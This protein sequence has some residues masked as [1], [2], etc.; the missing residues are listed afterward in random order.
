M[1]DKTLHT[2]SCLCGGVRYEIR[3]ELRPVHYCHCSQ[4]RKTSGN[5]VAATGCSD[6]AFTWVSDSTLSWYRASE[7]ARRGFCNVCGSNLFWKPDGEARIAI[8]AGTLDSTDSLVAES[9]I[10]V[11]DK[12]DYFT[13]GDGLPQFEQYD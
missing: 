7:V 3:G 11:A 4:C 5:F 6:D 10:F 8:F 2:G 12:A 13:I 9:H 1:T